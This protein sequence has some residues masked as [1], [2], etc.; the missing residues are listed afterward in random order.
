MKQKG[1]FCLFILLVFEGGC[2]KDMSNSLPINY[3]IQNIDI[4]AIQSLA[5]EKIFFAHMSVGYNILDGITDVIQ[6]DTRFNGL[7]IQELKNDSKVEK[8]GIYHTEIGK[9]G[10]PINKM[11]IALIKLCYADIDKKTNVET[12]FGY[13]Q[14]TIDSI[15]RHFPQLKIIHVTVPLYV[16]NWGFKLFIRNIIKNDYN[17]IRRNEFNKLLLEKY[18]NVDLIYDLAKIEST[19]PNG[20]RTTFG[21]DGVTYFSL[22]KYYTNDG[23]HLN[24]LGRWNAAK[25]LLILLSSRVC[26][27]VT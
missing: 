17:N 27:K 15:K 24:I 13:Y 14:D 23:G 11:D 2:K 22:S 4:K 10:F 5:R 1:L 6:H 12:L 21:H 25:E 8:F 18:Q 19:S 3:T 16:H 26:P 9:N 20:F 7:T